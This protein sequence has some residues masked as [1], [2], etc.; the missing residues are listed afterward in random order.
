MLI[1]KEA[2]KALGI[3]WIYAGKAECVFSDKS[4]QV[5][6]VLRPISNRITSVPLDRTT[7][8]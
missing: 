1:N 4:F 6:E 7:P 5:P 3:A 2:Q 8:N